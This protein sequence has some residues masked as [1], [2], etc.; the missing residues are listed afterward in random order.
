MKKMVLLIQLILFTIV[1]V[2]SGIHPIKRSVWFFEVLPAIILIVVLILTYKRFP[3]TPLSY[4]VI[5]FGT[6]TM[7]IGGHY[8][9]ARVPFFHDIKT[10]FHLKRNDFDRF[11]HIFYGMVTAVLMREYFIRTN[12]FHREKWL[13]VIVGMLSVSLSALY[14]IFEFGMAFLFKGDIQNFLGYQGDIFDSHWDIIC[15]LTGAIIILCLGKVHNKQISFITKKKNTHKK[16]YK[17]PKH[18][19]QPN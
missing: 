13:F 17:K 18:Q 16:K 2:W 9:Y 19:L 3:L 1:L 5:F 6:I 15:A 7:L 12:F 4:W 14:E 10:M 11:G 8:T